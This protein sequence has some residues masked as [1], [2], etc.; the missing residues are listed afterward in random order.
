MNYQKVWEAFLVAFGGFLSGGVGF[1]T[2]WWLDKRRRDTERRDAIEDRKRYFLAWMNQLLGEAMVPHNVGTYGIWYCNKVPNIL[3]QAATIRRDFNKGSRDEL[4]RLVGIL[5]GNTATIGTQHESQP[6]IVKCIHDV[7]SF[8][9][10]EM[11]TAD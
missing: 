8:V 2:G 11:K 6:I 7:V 1:L 10:K 5:T 3:Y 9:E 4:D